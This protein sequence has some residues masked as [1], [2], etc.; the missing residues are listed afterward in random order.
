[1][2]ESLFGQIRF[3]ILIDESEIAAIAKGIDQA[4]RKP[5]GE[6]LTRLA[7]VGVDYLRTLDDRIGHQ[8]LAGKWTYEGPTTT[9]LGVQ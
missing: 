9:A 5:A 4:I 1:M 7:K 8:Y 3:E 2:S 6:I